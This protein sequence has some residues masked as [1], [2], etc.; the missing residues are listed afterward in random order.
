LEQIPTG[1]PWVHV[2]EGTSRFEQRFLLRAAAQGLAQ[3]PVEVVMTTGRGLE[4]RDAIGTADAPNLHVTEWL[5]HDVLLPKCAA[6]VTTGGMGTVMVALRAGVPLVVVPS[7]WDKPANAKRVVDA[8]VG[9]ELEPR[10]CD[11]DALRAAIEEVLGDE[12]YRRNAMRAAELLAAA[13]GPKGAAELIENLAGAQ[14]KAP[15]PRPAAVGRA[16]A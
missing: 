15:G 3:A 13:P 14:P 4:A 9:V 10:R 12:R 7:G 11:P 6:I 16:S 8:G 5:S 1:R 2:T